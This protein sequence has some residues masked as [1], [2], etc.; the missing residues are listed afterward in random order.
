MNKAKEIAQWKR[1]K[2]VATTQKEVAMQQLN[3]ATQLESEA[4][5]RLEEL[6]SNSGRRPR[7]QHLTPEQKLKLVGGL[8]AGRRLV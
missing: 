5:T 2:A 3:T 7:A 6:G 8:T 1:I 4:E